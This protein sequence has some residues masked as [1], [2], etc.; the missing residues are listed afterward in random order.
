MVDQKK[1]KTVIKEI[2]GKNSD[3]LR[4]TLGSE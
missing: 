2:A 4:G 3:K 1:G